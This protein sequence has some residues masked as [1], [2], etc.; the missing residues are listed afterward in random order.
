MLAWRRHIASKFSYVPSQ[1][2]DPQKIQAIHARFA[3]ERRRFERDFQ[4]ALT[5]L[6]EKIGTLA[7][8]I[9]PAISSVNELVKKTAQARADIQ[10][11]NGL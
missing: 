8:Q 11:L 5:D 7:T 10:Y 9:P 2:I 1:A 3:S 4:V 6:K